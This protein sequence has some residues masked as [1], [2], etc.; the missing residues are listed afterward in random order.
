MNKIT[1]IILIGTSLLL[2]AFNSNGAERK[3][4][5]DFMVV[6][7]DYNLFEDISVKPL[8][9]GI[10]SWYTFDTG[11]LPAMYASVALFSYKDVVRFEVGGSSTWNGNKDRVDIS[12]LTGI[13]TLL[14]E[15]I[16]VGIWFA[17]FWNLYGNCP[18]DAW[19]GMIGYAF[20]L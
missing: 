12:P 1:K 7:R 4:P 9:V 6:G 2:L 20:T 13:S 14:A 18:D 17:P 3:S 8:S 10:N 11:V 15:K 5:R 19:G 16:V